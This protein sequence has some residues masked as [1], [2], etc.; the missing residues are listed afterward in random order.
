VGCWGCVW[1]RHGKSGSAS[2]VFFLGWCERE[3]VEVAELIQVVF[4][5]QRKVHSRGYSGEVDGVCEV[6][7][8]SY[9][10]VGVDAGWFGDL[11]RG[12]FQ[13]DAELGWL[14]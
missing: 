1:V 5:S 13:F 14:D 4:H 10:D 12:W 3:E 8:G 7:R 6:Q 2:A 11:Q 9:F